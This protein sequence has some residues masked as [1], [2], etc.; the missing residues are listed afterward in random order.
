M[1]AGNQR[2][3]L[4]LRKTEVLLEAL[5]GYAFVTLAGVGDSLL[6][7]RRIKV[8]H[9]ISANQKR[10]LRSALPFNLSLMHHKEPKPGVMTQC[11]NLAKTILRLLDAL[12]SLDLYND[13]LSVGKSEQKVCGVAFA[14][15]HKRQVE[16][17][18][19]NECEP[20]K[21]DG[22]EHEVL[23]QTTFVFNWAIL[24]PRAVD[25]SHVAFGR[26]CDDL[27]CCRHVSLLKMD[28]FFE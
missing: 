9:G 11:G 5:D 21:Q 6:Y 8:V 18:V 23:F 10:P 7:K 25:Q 13:P 12:R 22:P 15:F 16:G 20:G 4:L 24:K 14:V 1:A 28:H 2:E 3:Q 26:T 19:L 17:L 27:A